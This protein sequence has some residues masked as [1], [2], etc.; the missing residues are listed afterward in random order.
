MYIRG[1][2]IS[3]RLLMPIIIILAIYSIA[4]TMTK[5]ETKEPL[6]VDHDGPIYEIPVSE[7]T[8]HDVW[9]LCEENEF[10]YEL[11]LSIYEVEGFDNIKHDK[12]KADIEKLVFY[13]TYWA[14]Q[15]YPDEFV[16][17]LILISRLRGVA[18]CVIY[19]QNTES[20]DLNAYVQAVSDYKSFLEQSL[21]VT[22]AII[23]GET[24]AQN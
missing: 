20:Y 6:P 2:L 14:K 7:S 1:G 18:G 15:G 3:F 22:P 19:M 17:D 9:K 23:N 24:I 16:F 12:I 11:I 13:R 5:T 10:P 4:M 8:Q 21:D